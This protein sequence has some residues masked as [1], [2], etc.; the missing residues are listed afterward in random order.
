MPKCATGKC[1]RRFNVKEHLQTIV[2]V[3]GTVTLAVSL[4]IAWLVWRISKRDSQN[5]KAKQNNP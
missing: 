4:G 3:I 5:K 2:W 1:K